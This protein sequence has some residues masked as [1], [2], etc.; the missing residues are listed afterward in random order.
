MNRGK[1]VVNLVSSC[2]VYPC[3][4]EDSA[5]H[6]CQGAGVSQ[7]LLLHQQLAAWLHCCNSL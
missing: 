6:F 1:P 5:A 2:P 7:Q 4:Q 3:H